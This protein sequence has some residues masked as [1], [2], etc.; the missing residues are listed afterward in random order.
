MMYVCMY[1]SERVIS[2]IFLGRTGMQLLL[3]LEVEDIRLA[4]YTKCSTLGVWQS[5]GEHQHFG[6]QNCK[7]LM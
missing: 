4:F 3:K 6:G 5:K 1:R 7:E 2:W